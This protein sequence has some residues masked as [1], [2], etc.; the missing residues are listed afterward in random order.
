MPAFTHTPAR[1]MRMVLSYIPVLTVA[2]S[3]MGVH[4]TS[5]ESRAPNPDGLET[6]YLMP[7]M[8]AVNDARQK[9]G[10]D[11]K[12]LST[13]ET[14]KLR[15]GLENALDSSPLKKGQDGVISSKDLAGIDSKPT[16]DRRPPGGPSA[17]GTN[18]VNDS[19][20]GRSAPGG[21]VNDIKGKLGSDG[22]LPKE[23]AAKLKP[24]LQNTLDGSSVKNDKNVKDGR[25]SAADLCARDGAAC[26]YKPRKPAENAK[27]QG[28]PSLDELRNPCLAE[29][30]LPKRRQGMVGV[31]VQTEQGGETV[32]EAVPEARAAGGMNNQGVVEQRAVEI[33]V[34][35]EESGQKLDLGAPEARVFE[36][37][38][39]NRHVREELRDKVAE[40]VQDRVVQVAPAMV[41]QHP[42]ATVRQKED[43][44][45]LPREAKG[46]GVRL[47]HRVARKRRVGPT[48]LLV[49]DLRS[50]PHQ[51]AAESNR[52]LIEKAQQLDHSQD[53]SGVLEPTD[54]VR[55]EI[56]QQLVAKGSDKRQ[57]GSQQRALQHVSPRED[58]DNESQQPDRQFGNPQEDQHNASQPGDLHSVLHRNQREGQHSVNQLVDRHSESQ[59]GGQ[60]NVNQQRDLQHGNPQPGQH[61]ASQPGDLHSVNQLVDRHSKSQRGGQRSESHLGDQH[62]LSQH[63][64]RQQDRHSA[65]QQENQQED[66][67]NVN[68]QQR[69]SVNQHLDQQ[70]NQPH[71]Q[72]GKRQT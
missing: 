57:R 28:S 43:K 6:V 66:R 69:P 13:E 65:N 41:A 3:A 36:R 56:D 8:D 9:I 37:V 5:L 39:N 68:H 2:I 27:G 48:E 21:G 60:H 44:Q 67:H 14:K 23:D 15:P 40:R 47:E 29:A 71:G 10:Q 45:A 7:R 24:G 33:V 42:G 19:A 20:P 53:A 54:Q 49:A 50:E 32:Q 25:I 18:V 52:P 12:Y 46:Q 34:P 59:R 17:P 38:D 4:A 30:D 11:A 64:N 26:A 35:E 51:V 31:V 62:S 70:Q 22:Y 61:N 63:R 72:Q 58:Q 16:G 55:G 1:T